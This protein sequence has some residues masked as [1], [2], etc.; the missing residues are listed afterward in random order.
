MTAFKK[1]FGEKD[2]FPTRY[3]DDF[4]GTYLDENGQLIIK[5]SSDKNTKL[6]N[7][8]YSSY[9]D[10]KEIKKYNDDFKAD[11]IS[12]EVVY[13]H[14]EYSLNQLNYM[15]N[16]AINMVREDLPVLGSYVDTLN[17]RIVLEI[18]QEVFDKINNVDD[19]INL[20][21]NAEYPEKEIPLIIQPASVTQLTSN[22]PGGQF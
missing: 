21:R 12:D 19:K 11:R 2:G 17:N 5:I 8:D 15:M 10:I 22:H 1:K 6:L 4:A 3:P 9:I 20:Y 7:T 14:V 16:D 13:E 18:E